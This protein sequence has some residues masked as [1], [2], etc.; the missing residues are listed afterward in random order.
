MKIQLTID[1]VKSL[2]LNH[3]GLAED[4]VVEILD[5]T[6]VLSLINVIQSLNYRECDKI[7]AI[8]TYRQFANCGLA[9]AK[10]A[11]ENWPLA[12]EWMIQHGKFFIAH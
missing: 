5:T 3:L 6:S 9:E 12:K 10:Y 4:V 1:E 7:Q 8:K 2:V 11:V